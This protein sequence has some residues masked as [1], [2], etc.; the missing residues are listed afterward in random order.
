MCPLQLALDFPFTQTAQ[1]NLIVFNVNIKSFLYRYFTAH[2]HYLVAI[3]QAHQQFCVCVL[4][5]RHLATHTLNKIQ[6]R[7]VFFPFI[8]LMCIYHT[9]NKLS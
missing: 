7:H 5:I 3:I 4:L 2:T 8:I 9:H 6:I 1:T